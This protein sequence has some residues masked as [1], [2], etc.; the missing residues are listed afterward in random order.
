MKRSLD[1]T[2]REDMSKPSE[3]PHLTLLGVMTD[4]VADEDRTMD[5]FEARQQGSRDE[6]AKD[7][8][9]SEGLKVPPEPQT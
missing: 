9:G 7:G 3:R 2:K 1:W 4:A 6:E 8:G 5:E